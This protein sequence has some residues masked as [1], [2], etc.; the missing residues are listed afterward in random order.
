MFLHTYFWLYYVKG[1]DSYTNTEI[2]TNSP[3]H[4]LRDTNT[5]TDK[6]NI[7]IQTQNNRHINT[8]RKQ[9][10]KHADTYNIH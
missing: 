3:M 6:N 7:K 1:L 10:D 5:D 4:A 9:T 8:P 2:H